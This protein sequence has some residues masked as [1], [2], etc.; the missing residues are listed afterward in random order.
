MAGPAAI[1]LEIHRLRRFARDLQEQLDRLPKQLKAY[2][3][4]VTKAEEALRQ[5][6][7]GVRHWKVKATDT[8]KTL[9]A[10]HGDI[11]RFEKQRDTAGSTKEY[12]A[13]G[14]EIAHAR[15]KCGELENEVL[16]AMEE[17]EKLEAALPGL[18]K[19]V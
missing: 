9:K 6:K 13:L 11:A 10:R 2:Q 8:E 16:A 3:A 7:E 19:A 15:E 4:R 18:E 12:E 14:H 1:F 17:G 5:A